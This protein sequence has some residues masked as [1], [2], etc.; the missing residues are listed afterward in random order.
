MCRLYFLTGGHSASKREKVEGAEN[1]D[2]PGI[3][4]KENVKVAPTIVRKAR[5]EALIS[6]AA[7]ACQD[8]IEVGGSEHGGYPGKRKC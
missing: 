5:G 3:P 7:L 4:G 8:Q 2:I 6:K 1:R